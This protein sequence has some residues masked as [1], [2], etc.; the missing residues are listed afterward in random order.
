[1]AINYVSACTGGLTF[2]ID[3]ADGE[4]WRRADS[5]EDGVY[6]VQK[7]GTA[8]AVYGSSSMD[9]ATEEGFTKDD[10]AQKMWNTILE[11]S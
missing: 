3:T 8:S 5:I 1:M 9:F 7:Y 11:A 10:G 2:C 6:F 4:I